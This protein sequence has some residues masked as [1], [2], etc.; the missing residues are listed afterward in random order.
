MAGSAE[1]PC[2]GDLTATELRADGSRVIVPHVA[3]P[4]PTSTAS[5]SIR[6]STRLLPG[7]HTDFADLGPII[8]VTL[9]QA[10][11]FDEVVRALRAALPPDHDRDVPL[12]RQG[13]AAGV[14]FPTWRTRSCTTWVS[15]TTVARWC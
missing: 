5:T 11:L 10:A 13:G 15:T 7:N 9:A 1:S 6:R 8:D 2:H 3:A 4:H 12:G 14:A